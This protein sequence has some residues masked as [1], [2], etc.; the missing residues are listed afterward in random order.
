MN[1]IWFKFII[2]GSG[3]KEQDVR[4]QSYKFCAL[5]PK[6]DTICHDN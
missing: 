5:E 1:K 4:I 3:S 2:L 6:D